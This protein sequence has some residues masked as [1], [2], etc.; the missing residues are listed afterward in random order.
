VVLHCKFS[1]DREGIPNDDLV[2]CPFNLAKDPVTTITING[3]QSETMKP[4]SCSEFP[5]T[6]MIPSNLT[7]SESLSPRGC[8]ESH[9]RSDFD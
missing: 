9:A 1:F 5:M 4:P 6:A 8:P 3:Y 2:F 7:V